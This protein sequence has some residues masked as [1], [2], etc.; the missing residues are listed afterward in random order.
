MKH[1]LAPYLATIVLGACF[2]LWPGIVVAGA[3]VTLRWLE[4]RRA[5]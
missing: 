1:P 3:V 5:P 4:L 2:G